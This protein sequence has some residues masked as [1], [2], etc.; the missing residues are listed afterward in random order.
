MMVLCIGRRELGKTTLAMC[1]ARHYDT[2]VIF[3]PRHMINTT[4]DI[5]SEENI[6]G[7]LYGMLDTRAEIIIQPKFDKQAA[8]TAMCSEVYDWLNDNPGEKVCILVDEIRFVLL[9]DPFFDFLIR[10]TP[11]KDVAIVLTA[12][13]VVDVPTDLRRIA[14]IWCI[15]KITLANDLEK[16]EER[17]GPEVAEMVATL[18]PYE[19]VVWDDSIAKSRK[20]TDKAS[21]FV[22]LDTLQHG[23]ITQ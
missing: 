4:S 12:H 10:C 20:N 2:R 1:V 5:L 19:F 17:A 9:D 16:I 6:S 7:V 21:W 14:D 15:F 23:A 13:G 8:F 3:D 18:N 22:Q 11:R